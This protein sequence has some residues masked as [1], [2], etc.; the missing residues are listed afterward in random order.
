[1]AVKW[2][3]ALRS[4]GDRKDTYASLR[5]AA[6]GLADISGRNVETCLTALRRYTPGQKMRA[7]RQS[8]PRCAAILALLKADVK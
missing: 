7:P 3:V 4:V 5:D 2:E 8:C 1:M 6:R